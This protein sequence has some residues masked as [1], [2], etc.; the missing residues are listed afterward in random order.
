MKMVSGNP[1]CLLE[2]G[3]VH[4]WLFDLD[5]LSR[6]IPAWERLLSAEEVTR[7][8]HY[9]FDRDRLRFV[10][11][12]GILR[13]LLG[14]YIGKN[15]AGISYHTSPYG[16]LS[17]PSHPLSFNL[18]TSQNRMAFVF[19]LEK[20]VGVD[21]EQVR[22]I[23]EISKL[24]ER[25]FSQAEQA[26]L[27]ALA[28]DVQAEA[29]F[30][31]WTQKEAFIKAHGEGLSLPLKDFSVSVNPDKPGRL[32]S[33]IINQSDEACHWQMTSAIPEKGWRAAVCL[34]AEAEP[35]IRWIKTQEAD[36]NEKTFQ[37]IRPL[38][39]NRPSKM[40][41]FFHSFNQRRVPWITSL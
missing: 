24:A 16:K 14:R 12:R 15:P 41:P 30:H 22:P 23:P 19:T 35:E 20:D 31:I 33:F 40:I 25:W 29:F 38:L 10:A 1:T 3:E 6:E 39:Y 27:S 34:R 21:I 7:S 17:L 5:H 2:Q 18:S 32:L 36:I 37:N 8:K 26:G 11:R 9:K 4:F 28:P 13:Q